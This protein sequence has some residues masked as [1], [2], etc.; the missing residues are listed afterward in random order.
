[1]T[2]HDGS[3]P[4]PATE[5]IHPVAAVIDTCFFG[6][7]NFK[8]DHVETLAGRLARRDVKLWIPAQVIDE[9]A[10]HAFEAIEELQAAYTKLGELTIAGTPPH[11]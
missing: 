2:D 8:P 1:M 4:E 3:K 7:G 6:A 10:I 5:S 9:W 11:P